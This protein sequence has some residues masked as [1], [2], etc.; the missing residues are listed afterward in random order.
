MATF[1]PPVA[2]AATTTTTTVATFD[3][4]PVNGEFKK[5]TSVSNTEYAKYNANTPSQASSQNLHSFY[6]YLENSFI[7]YYD[8][9]TTNTTTATGSNASINNG[10]YLRDDTSCLMD[11][12]R[13]QTTTYSQPTYQ[14]HLYSNYLYGMTTGTGSAGT[15]ANT[16]QTFASFEV[17]PVEQ[18]TATA[19]FVYEDGGT[20]ENENYCHNTGFYQSFG[21]CFNSRIR[22][23]EK[24]TTAT[25]FLIESENN[26]SNNDSIQEPFKTMA[27]CQIDSTLN[28]EVQ[29][30]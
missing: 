28:T 8:I 9:T 30:K 10:N 27:H 13:N 3:L 15:S 22:S 4:E 24:S 16:G 7:N 12:G 11:N 1:D 29:I 17:Q 19:A 5:S 14:S 26:N 25:T 6:N 21:S 23:G 2:A 20:Y 18:P